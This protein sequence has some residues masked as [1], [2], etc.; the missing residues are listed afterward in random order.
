MHSRILSTV[1]LAAFVLVFIGVPG[2]LL[3]QQDDRG[4]LGS[5]LLATWLL[6]AIVVSAWFVP[7][8]I[9]RGRKR[10][11][12]YAEEW[13][14]RLELLAA[15]RP[16]FVTLGAMRLPGLA[17]AVSALTDG[18]VGDELRIA[19]L[20][21]LNEL[22][23]W[24]LEEKAIR[25]TR[26]SGEEIEAIEFKPLRRGAVVLTAVVRRSN[27][28]VR[29]PMIGL[30]VGRDQSTET[31]REALRVLIVEALR[32]GVIPESVDPGLLTR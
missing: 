1:G 7:R 9:L 4:D 30:H 13:K 26:F 25:V 31:G 17:E 3:A 6:S 24:V 22:Q 18:A 12:I 10:C 2:Y 23:L 28:T 27:E 29:V 5:S 32:D 11:R 21:R 16:G 19:W 15:S 20:A 8:E 14:R